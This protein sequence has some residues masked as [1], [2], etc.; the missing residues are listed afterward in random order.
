MILAAIIALQATKPIELKLK[1]KAGDRYEYST[2]VH[3]ITGKPGEMMHAALQITER[4]IA[5]TPEF[6]EISH[7]VHEVT[8]QSKGALASSASVF[9]GLK[10]T[11]FQSKQDLRGKSLDPDGMGGSAASASMELVYPAKPIS[12]GARWDADLNINGKLIKVTYHFDGIEPLKG[13]D[14]YKLVRS[15]V[16][17]QV[18]KD[19]DPTQIW[20]S[21]KDGRIFRSIG[22]FVVESEGTKFTF[23][24]KVQRLEV[25]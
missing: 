18:I 19:V 24:H 3:L 1:V 14:M 5:A 10:N 15:I 17:G 7:Y 11:S 13:V 16:P 2:E 22:K 25:K 8:V 23:T 20:V 21:P 4:I 9:D 6:V 12:P